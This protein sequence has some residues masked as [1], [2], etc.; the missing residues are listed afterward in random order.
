[1]V[2]VQIYGGADPRKCQLPARVNGLRE[3]RRWPQEK[4]KVTYSGGKL[5]LCLSLDLTFDRLGD[6]T[7]WLVLCGARCSPG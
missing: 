6:P 7:Q 1:M 2:T 5:D 4:D 3:Q